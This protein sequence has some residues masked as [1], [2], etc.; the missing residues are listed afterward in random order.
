MSL[1]WGIGS[2]HLCSPHEL[3]R[4]R[5]SALLEGIKNESE[6]AGAVSQVQQLLKQQQAMSPFVGLGRWRHGLTRMWTV[7]VRRNRWPVMKENNGC[8][9]DTK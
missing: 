8:E 9:G 2:T 4:K 6:R 5:L 1:Q 3:I 7:R